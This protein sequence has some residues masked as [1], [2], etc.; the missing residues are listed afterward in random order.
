ML[1]AR[2]QLDNVNERLRGI[3]VELENTRRGDP[4]HLH[5]RQLEYDTIQVLLLKTLVYLFVY[6]LR[7]LS[8]S[9][10]RHV[11]IFVLD[12]LVVY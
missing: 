11:N 2:E 4:K 1:E 8:Q 7:S 3:V 10:L 6:K 12:A 9:Q 5:L